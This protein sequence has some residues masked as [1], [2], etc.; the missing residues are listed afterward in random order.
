[1]PDYEKVRALKG[2]PPNYPG[3]MDQQIARV[4][5]APIDRS[6]PLRYERSGGNARYEI[7]LS[8]Q[9]PKVVTTSQWYYYARGGTKDPTIKA[10]DRC[11]TR[12][13]NSL[14]SKVR[15]ESAASLGTTLAEWRESADFVRNRSAA[16][17]SI[18]QAARLKNPALFIH[19]LGLTSVSRNKSVLHGLSK[20]V[21]DAVNL[22]LEIKFGVQPLMSDIESAIRT[23]G[24]DMP[25]LRIRSQSSESGEWVEI[26][27]GYPFWGTKGVF[28]VRAGYTVHVVRVNPNALLLN[29]LGLVNP[30]ATFWDVQPLSFVVNWVLPVSKFLNSFTGL[31]GLSLANC[32]VQYSGKTSGSEDFWSGSEGTS[33]HGTRIVG[34][35]FFTNRAPIGS[36]PIPSFKQQYAAHS[37]V[38]NLVEAREK[39]W[40]LTQLLTQRADLTKIRR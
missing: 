6:K 12:A 24:R 27:R 19:A 8:N 2:T 38:N 39:L 40:T 33:T 21:K 17:L 11:A 7:N 23:L 20:A 15:G 36:P 26:L 28:S 16:I 29:S 4:Q 18:V 9:P 3:V 32:S 13:Y 5:K 22:S 34:E 37:T 14:V 31:I 30:V 1:M 25:P 10:Y 35:A